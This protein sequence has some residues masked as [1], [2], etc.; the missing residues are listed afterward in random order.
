M[1]HNHCHADDKKKDM[2]PHI[3]VTATMI[4]AGVRE[5]RDKRLGE[6]LSEI[7]ESV[8]YA[9]ALA[10]SENQGLGFSE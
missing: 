6:P 5:L 3:E 9:M 8:Y 1:E 10:A 7:V 4:D 2:L